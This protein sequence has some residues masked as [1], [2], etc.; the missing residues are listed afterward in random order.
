MS[1]G[2]TDVPLWN[3]LRPSSLASAILGISSN[4]G[5]PR[6]SSLFTIPSVDDCGGLE[7]PL[8]GK[9]VGVRPDFLALTAAQTFWRERRA[10]VQKSTR[11]R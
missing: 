5:L 2:N 6:A 3:I 10:R 9:S 1:V 8:Y 7:S 11:V 4:L